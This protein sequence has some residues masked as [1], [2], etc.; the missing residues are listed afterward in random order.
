MAGVLRL[1]SVR[2]GTLVLA[3][4]AVGFIAMAGTSFIEARWRKELAVPPPS[5]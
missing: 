2:L 1:I 3:L 5:P 4:I